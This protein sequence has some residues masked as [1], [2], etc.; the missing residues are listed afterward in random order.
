MAA[1]PVA[2]LPMNAT[3]SAV[4]PFMMGGGMGGSPGP[5]A[6]PGETKTPAPRISRPPLMTRL[7]SV[8]IPVRDRITRTASPPLI[9]TRSSSS[10]SSSASS[11]AAPSMVTVSI[12]RS[13]DPTSVIVSPP[14]SS[15]NTMVSAPA[16][17]GVQPSTAAFVLAASTASRSEQSPSAF[18]SSA[19]V[20]TVMVAA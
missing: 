14:K 12:V 4:T 8:S 7:R 19:L 6:V 13:P 1:G 9:V 17:P 20:V 5:P 11:P 18:S 3:F 10:S 15:A 2:S 16:S